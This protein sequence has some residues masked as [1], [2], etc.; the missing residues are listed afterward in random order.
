MA[1]GN[2]VRRS[3]FRI[4]AMSCCGLVRTRPPVSA[5]VSGDR[6]SVG[7]SV[8]R[9]ALVVVGAGAVGGDHLLRRVSAVLPTWAH[10]L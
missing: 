2:V 8:A 3:C 5:A 7:Y 10:A 6:Y 1:S 4:P 9:V